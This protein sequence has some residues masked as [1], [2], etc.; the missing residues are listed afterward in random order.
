M[1]Q[2]FTRR[3][4][5]RVKPTTLVSVYQTL[6]S[7]QTILLCFVLNVS[8]S[9]SFSGP[10][11][12]SARYKLF[13]VDGE[14]PAL[15]SRHQEMPPYHWK[16]SAVCQWNVATN[17][18]SLR[19]VV[20]EHL[21]QP[22]TFGHNDVGGDD[23]IVFEYDCPLAPH[24]YPNHPPDILPDW[25]GHFQKAGL[26]SN[27]TVTDLSWP[28]THDSLSYDLS[29]TVSEDGLDN[30]QRL[31]EVLHLMSGGKLHLLPGELEEFWRMQAKTQQLTVTQQLDNGIRFLDF[32]MMMEQDSE[33][34]Y[35]VHFMQSNNVVQHYWREIRAWLDLHPNEIIMIWLSREGNPTATGQ[36]QFPKVSQEQ[37]HKLWSNYL[38]IFDGLLMDSRDSSIFETQLDEMVAKNY[39]VVTFMADYK[40]FTGSSPFSLNAARIEN[41]YD[42]GDGVFSEE[43]TLQKHRYYFQHARTN[44]AAARAIG[45]FTLLAMNSQVQNWQILA[46][47][48]KR[49]LGW[50]HDLLH[51]CSA[52]LNIPNT[53][54]WCPEFLLDIVQLASYYNQHVFEFAL[55]SPTD[56][57]V[58]FVELESSRT[59]AF[60]N[61]FYL[62]ALDYDGT[63][64]TSSILLDGTERGGKEG[65]EVKY[66]YVDT[67]LLYNLRQ[68]LRKKQAN[69]DDAY[70]KL[71]NRVQLRRQHNPFRLWD[72][73]GRA[74]HSDWPRMYDP[75]IIDT[76]AQ[77]SASQ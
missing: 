1:R 40:E 8:R 42:A 3:R 71:F 2:N 56:G 59:L 32:R 54:H 65:C 52:H 46:A 4:T 69:D 41:H 36:D 28:G 66:A 76:D 38:E 24:P 43:E 70:Q 23:V 68:A 9:F 12:T 31:V 49:F 17:E 7:E 72:D 55:P 11:C 39:R 5:I 67:V 44:N 13:S 74:R 20:D 77:Q 19:S 30:F 10:S 27:V 50:S 75:S 62:D 6:T 37:K 21:F 26:L 45:H 47:A 51:R 63:V 57:S 48:K 16:R 64:R 29:L 15:T 35:S 34:W 60:P 33:M 22:F 73:H 58:N 53:S 14:T 61:A 25:L 18:C